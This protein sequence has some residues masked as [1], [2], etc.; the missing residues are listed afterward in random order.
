MYAPDE[1]AKSC[2]PSLTRIALRIS[3]HP[4]M[5]ATP[6]TTDG[7]AC[8]YPSVFTFHA[9]VPL[10]AIN[11]Y[12]LESYEPISTLSPDTTGDDFTSP[13]VLNVHTGLPVAT[14][15]ACTTPDRSPMNT[16]PPATAGDDSPMPSGEAL[17]FHFT[18]PSARLSAC[19]SPFCDP[20]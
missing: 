13:S 5:Y 7:V 9:S 10:F 8:T 14:S 12:R 1:S 16:R 15:T 2:R 19:R 11:A 18:L 3:S 4:V 6:S 20:T 17:Y